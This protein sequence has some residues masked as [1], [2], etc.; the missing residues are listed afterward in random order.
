MLRVE[1]LQDRLNEGTYG[2]AF[3]NKWGNLWSTVA[4]YKGRNIKLVIVCLTVL[5]LF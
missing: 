2:M 4:N 3:K 1:R 5:A